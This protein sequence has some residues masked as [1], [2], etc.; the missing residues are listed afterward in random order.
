LPLGLSSGDTEIVSID[1]DSTTGNIFIAGT[2]TA[3][4]LLVSGATKSVFTAMYNGK[5]YVWV[6]VVYSVL[7]DTVEFM[8]A[9]GTAS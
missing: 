9:M 6:K 4:E 1:R 5:T 2:T 7:I 3:K 8:S